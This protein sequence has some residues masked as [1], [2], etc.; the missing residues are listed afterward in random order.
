MLNWDESMEV[1]GEDEGV[2]FLDNDDD[3]DVAAADEAT[4]VEEDATAM[5][6]A[7]R[8]ETRGVG[9]A[10]SGTSGESLCM[11]CWGSLASK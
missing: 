4:V 7:E 8:A 2:L 11:C 5:P 1:V 6:V 3:D 10:S 9:A